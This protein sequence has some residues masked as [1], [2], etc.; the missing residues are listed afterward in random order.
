MFS[1]VPNG[2]AHEKRISTELKEKI[3]E[4]I[5]DTGYKQN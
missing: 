1:F 5:E 3:L 4:T 2:R